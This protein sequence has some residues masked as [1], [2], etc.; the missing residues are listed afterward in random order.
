MT[1]CNED[2]QVGKPHF[3]GH[4]RQSGHVGGQHNKNSF[5]E[6]T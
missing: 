5:K 1:I 6:F 4:I 3:K 2:Q